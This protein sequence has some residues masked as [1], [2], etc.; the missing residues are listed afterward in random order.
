LSTWG[1]AAAG[2]NYWRGCVFLVGA[3]GRGPDPAFIGGFSTFPVMVKANLAI[4]GSLVITMARFV[5]LSPAQ[6]G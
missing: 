2:F 5:N 1:D 4:V 3:A 6:D